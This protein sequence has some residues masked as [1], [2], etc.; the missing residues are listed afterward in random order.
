M[1]LYNT[2][3]SLS[4]IS[5]TAGQEYITAPVVLD[6]LQKYMPAHVDAMGSVIGEKD[7][8]GCH[9]LLDAH[10]DSIGLIVTSVEENGFLRVDKCGGA[11][12]RVLAAQEV[13]VHGKENLYGVIT[14]VPPHLLKDEGKKAAGFDELMI[15]TGLDGKKAKELVKPGDRVTFNSYCGKM[16]GSVLRGAY[17]DDKAGVCAILRCL[18]ILDE[19]N[20]D[21]KITVLFSS[22]EETGGTGAAAA[23]FSCDAEKCISVDVS[24]AKT[25]DTP[26]EITASLGKGVMIGVSPALSYPMSCELQAL[27]KSRNIPYQLEIMPS[28]TGTN[29]DSL[30]VSSGGKKAALL[31]I[32][33][34]NMHT[35]VETVSLDDIESAARLMAEYILN[36]G[37]LKV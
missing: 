2:L 12:V 31:S 10:L 7:G 21:K 8:R 9:Y 23:G 5:A 18:E 25:A 34:K 28:S 22:Q 37:G 26:R 32:P 4:Q 20:C 14:C 19:N 33:I 16:L 27:A 15:D 1:D 11:D 3:I 13:T 35:A 30:A 6:L 17:F 36:D 29:A 24:F